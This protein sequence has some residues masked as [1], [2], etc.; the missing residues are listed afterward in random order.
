MTEPQNNHCR[1]AVYYRPGNVGA[2]DY[3]THFDCFHEPHTETLGAAQ[4]ADMAIKIWNNATLILLRCFTQKIDC[5]G[6]L[7]QAANRI[8]EFLR[9][10]SNSMEQK[11][12]YD[13]LERNCSFPIL[14]PELDIQIECFSHKLQQLLGLEGALS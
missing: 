3:Q 7:D 8:S 12:G 9:K 6:L 11:M 1:I 2:S 4:T 13:F 10:R 5:S 14:N